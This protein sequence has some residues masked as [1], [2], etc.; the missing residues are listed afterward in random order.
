MWHYFFKNAK[1]HE[2]LNDGNNKFL[3]KSYLCCFNFDNALLIKMVCCNW[4]ENCLLPK[5]QFCPP[6]HT[7]QTRVAPDRGA[8]RALTTKQA[9]SRLAGF[10]DENH[11]HSVLHLFTSRSAN[12]YRYVF[13]LFVFITLFSCPNFILPHVYENK[14][15]KK[16][17][18]PHFIAKYPEAILHLKDVY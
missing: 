10:T 8:A 11:D 18:D 2:S 3:K 15:D 9:V 5:T 16:N 12:A 4:N 17:I 14:T 13:H 6:P 7:C 1:L